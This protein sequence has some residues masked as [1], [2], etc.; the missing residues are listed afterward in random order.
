M[1]VCVCVC[2]SVLSVLMCWASAA[3]VAILTVFVVFIKR[4]YLL[5]IGVVLVGYV[6]HD[7]R[8]SNEPHTNNTV[9][10]PHRISMS[11]FQA[12]SYEYAVEM[13]YP[14]PEATSATLLNLV[15]QDLIIV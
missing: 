3:S 13:T 10:N 7:H 14:L 12:I 11:D 8:F 1:C 6:D 2:S 4:F 5:Y 15:S 9:F